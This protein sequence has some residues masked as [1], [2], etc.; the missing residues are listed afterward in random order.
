M[1]V[2]SSI[3]TF[4][5]GMNL[6]SD[7]SVLDK[8]TIRYAQNI[9]L[10]TNGEGTSAII[11]NSD[12]IQKYNIN[13]PSDR[14]IIGTV[15][16]KYCTCDNN[17]CT[18][19]ECAVVFTKDD[20]GYNYVYI[21]DFDL[22]Q[23]KRIIAGEFGWDV[24]LSLV[25]NFES[26]DVSIVYIADGKNPLRRLNIA[27]DYGI[28]TDTTIL[29]MIPSSSNE[30][31]EFVE[32]I[33]G[34]LMAGKIQYSYQLFTEYGTTSTISPL[35]ELIS[36]SDTISSNSSENV[37]GSQ[38]NVQ[39]N[40]GVALK[41]QFVNRMYDRIRIYR[42]S[43]TVA[44]QL[45]TI[46]IVDEVKIP[47]NIG[48]QEFEYRDYG[49][50]FLSVITIDEFNQ[51]I[52]P[53]DFTAKT[54]ESKDN[55]LFAAN[56]TEDTWDVEYDSRAYRADKN[57]EVVLY[58]S[59][60]DMLVFKIDEIPD[61]DKE[62]DCLNPSN[63]V[64]TGEQQLVYNYNS[65]G[66]LGGTGKNISYDFIFKEI[67]LSSSPATDDKV[68]KNL[69][70][71]VDDTNNNTTLYDEDGNSVSDPL[72][73]EGYKVMNYSD[74][75]VC[76]N[77]TGYQRDEIYRFGIVL[78][79]K[80]GVASPVH[81]IGDIRIPSS[82]MNVSNNSFVN[83]FQV[84][85]Y[86]NTFK[87]VIDLSGYAVGIRFTVSNLPDDVVSYEIVRC[88]RTIDNRTIITQA[89]MSS[90]ITDK[91]NVKANGDIERNWMFDE[92]G[93]GDKELRPQFL[94]NL[95]KN[96]TT[97][98]HHNKGIDT[99][100]YLSED[101]YYEIVSPE[102]CVDRENT[103]Q[104]IK[105]AKLCNMYELYTY[106]GDTYNL[107]YDYNGSRA[108]G[109][110]IG[111][112]PTHV[113][114]IDGSLNENA[115]GVHWT[116]DR[117]FLGQRKVAALYTGSNNKMTEN[118]QKYG[119]G[120]S[121]VFKYYNT[122][123][124]N[125]TL[126]SFNIEEAIA[127]Q[128]IATI[129]EFKN[130]KDYQQPIYNKTYTN[131][132]IAGYKQWGFHGKNIIIK[133]EDDFAKVGN[134][135]IDH[136]VETTPYGLMNCAG[137]YNI[138][139]ASHIMSDSYSSRTNSVYISCGAYNKNDATTTVINCFGGDTYLCVLDYLNTSFVQTKN[140]SQDYEGERIH[141]QCYIPFET[142]IN[143]NL[144]TNKQYHNTIN[145]TGMIG[146][147]LVQNEPIVLAGY[148]QSTPQYIYNSIY[149]Q[150]GNVIS[151]VNKSLYQRDD[152]VQNNRIIAS[153]SKR[154]LEITDSWTKFK[155]ANYLDIDNQYGEITNL[156]RFANRLYFFQNSAVGVASVN[157]RSLITDS[158]MAELTLGT[159]DILTRYDYISTIN[160]N[161]LINDKSIVNSS[162]ALYWYDYSNNVL[163]ALS[164]GIIEL[165]KV[166]G[167]QS[168]L[169][170]NYDLKQVRKQP[171][172]VLNKKYDEVWFKIIDTPIVYS[173]QL[174]AFTSFN[175]H[176][177]D[178]ALSF[179]GKIVTIKN[180]QF[181]QHN[182]TVVGNKYV[183]PL[184]SKFNIVVNDNF[185]YTKVYDNISFYADFNNQNNITSAVFKTKTQLSNVIDSNNI[186]CR[187][188]T[189]RFCI[190]RES[191]ENNNM[192]YVGRM[193]GKYLEQQY[194]FD[195]NDNKTFKIP[196]I[197]TTYR[198]SML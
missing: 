121:N 125:K 18:P 139:K 174:G 188:D 51:L 81:W 66:K 140:D 98:F 197:K 160:G 150:Q 95:S 2:N 7:I 114:K 22:N 56:I 122:Y 6:D 175:T 69:L 195:C 26:C 120:L 43:Y 3:N 31:F 85:K 111:V 71:N 162:S 89:I 40:K 171:V 15:E 106:V 82:L 49:G 183:E 99:A 87:K 119:Y 29:D 70:L 12:Y 93:G 129:V 53:Y 67:V 35:S 192:S 5:K 47:T 9:R 186:E 13:I 32:L 189:Y 182:E 20:N 130:T 101:N 159:G 52:Y 46:H 164:N 178:Y 123:K 79:N 55:I 63:L 33:D 77:Y 166:K 185:M 156:K 76:A 158:N 19:K 16:A 176:N 107:T 27:K 131:T 34:N 14:S 110:L 17:V 109:Y 50:N 177:F 118:S 74:S 8:N 72:T 116:N 124:R 193:R 134:P 48:Y 78:Y 61:I 128:T 108:K 117:D 112:R 45:P 147:N 138:K 191:G 126:Q 75:W 113:Y 168:Y 39:T 65:K 169:N 152:L 180:N 57:G 149:S 62:H 25:S 102:I 153:E 41:T 23:L 59:N 73:Q 11:Q 190:P 136:M 30:P 104:L 187:E 37:Y 88:A 28:I 198:Q 64:L 94:F 21:V 194:T 54:I 179:N 143:L 133:T 92:G 68:A 44:G 115:L 103:L 24:G 135:Y 10:T 84:G 97:T 142:T 173:E 132:S 83:P 167:V 60:K 1:E 157:D 4:Y 181:Y 100:R 144:L 96:L 163:C 151:F 196:Y 36:I 80:K 146:Q 90:L 165:S 91:Q 161:C 58:D 42:I 127:P 38:P 141:T 170:S 184:I 86:S 137:V 172:S 148:T 105:N 154:N 145:G 155:Y